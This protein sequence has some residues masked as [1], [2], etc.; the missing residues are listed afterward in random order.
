M[1]QGNDRQTGKPKPLEEGFRSRADILGGQNFGFE[2][3]S[4]DRLDMARR[5]MEWNGKAEKQASRGRKCEKNC[6]HASLS[7]EIGQDPTRE[8]MTEAAQGFL[9]NLGMENAQAVFI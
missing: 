6:L 2:I 8:E 5:M 9:K 1:G 4:A 7:W 3:D